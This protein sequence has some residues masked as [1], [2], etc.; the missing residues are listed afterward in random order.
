M[1]GEVGPG[2]MSL[3][4]FSESTPIQAQAYSTTILLQRMP[5]PGFLEMSS[6][7]HNN[8]DSDLLAANISRTSATEYSNVSSWV[9]PTC[10]AEDEAAFSDMQRS[11]SSSV[12]EGGICEVAVS[13]NARVCRSCMVTSATFVC[14][15]HAY[16]S[17]TLTN[18][19]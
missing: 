12:C 11:W 5:R 1:T 4:H 17:E 2:L 9:F 14:Q 19:V 7:D 18:K 3:L 10:A 15:N 6:R 16:A 13:V 8:P